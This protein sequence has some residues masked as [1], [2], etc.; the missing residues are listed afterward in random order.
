MKPIPASHMPSPCP[1]PPSSPPSKM[2]RLS[3]LYS[4]VFIDACQIIYGSK[5]IISQGGI[6]SVDDMFS[7]VA[8]EGKK[9][10]DA[11]CGVG[12]TDIYLAQKYNVEI[13]GVDKEPYMT[14]EAE[15]L[16]SKQQ[17]PL[18]GRVRF[19]TLQAPTSLR[20]FPDN[21]FDL[22]YSKEMLYHVPVENKQQYVNEMFR[23][24]KPG[25]ILVTAD[26]H[27]HAD[28]LGAHLNRVLQFGTPGFC[29]FITP[30]HFHT[31]LKTAKFA[32]ILF[33]DVSQEHINY[34]KKDICRLRDKASKLCRI[35][36]SNALKRWTR[37]WNLFHDALESGDLRASI[38]IA[39]KPANRMQNLLHR[40]SS[41]FAKATQKEP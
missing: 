35:A 13:L 15:K 22:V 36:D 24:L 6:Q 4:P 5:G 12:G 1:N 3:N 19:Q 2:E 7:G 9:I 16:L 11:G 18:K 14:S 38:F 31:I 41:L 27:S 34:Q 30:K 26:W 39:K 8:L 23:V 32:N 37:N 28:E 29:Y 21:T 25:G 33:R 10:L 40:V 20:E 17:R